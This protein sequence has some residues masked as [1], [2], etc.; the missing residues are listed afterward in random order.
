MG[1]KNFLTG[2]LLLLSIY[3]SGW[4]TGFIMILNYYVH[5]SGHILFGYLSNFLIFKM[6]HGLHW[7][8]WGKLWGI[9]FPKQTTFD[10]IWENYLFIFGGPILFI[11]F[12]LFLVYILKKRLNIQKKWL[13]N[14]VF[15][16]MIILYF[17]DGIVGNVFFGTDNWLMN[18]T[19]VLAY[20]NHPVLD[21]FMNKVYPWIFPL[22]LI[23]PIWMLIHPKVHKFVIFL[24]EKQKKRI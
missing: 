16:P 20:S 8:A 10:L 13:E 21:Y 23:I 17:V 11:L 7:S 6:P 19:S 15:I 14:V 22:A 12:G 5:E 4:I 9:S 24:Q 1:H 2:S 3:I 18:G